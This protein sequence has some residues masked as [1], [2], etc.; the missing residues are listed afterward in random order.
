MRGRTT[1][2]LA[3]SAAFLA[4]GPNNREHVSQ[5]AVAKPVVSA[6]LS[7][8]RWFGTLREVMHEGRVGGVVKLADV[9]PGPHAWGLGALEG[10]HGEVTVL[11][12]RVWLAVPGP[13]G[14]VVMRPAD[15]GGA[16]REQQAALFVVANVSGWLELVLDSDIP[17]SDL[18][19]FLKQRLAASG[20]TFD[21]PI[22]VRVEGPVTMLRW[23]V[24]D[25]SK[26]APGAT[27]AEHA[28]TAIVGRLENTDVSLV[29]FFSEHHQGVFTHAGSSSHFHVVSKTPL[30]S[31]HVDELA[32]ARGARLL[33]PARSP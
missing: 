9:V 11:D 21:Q 4:C 8:V 5:Q 3:L 23:H 22:P 15:L 20:F 33:V 19:A 17:S 2:L 6:E 7:P 13:N 31:G 24:V 25:G 12:D 32:L 10:L 28:R 29:G 14:Q 26:L 27:H 16:D 30:V 18:D 1:V